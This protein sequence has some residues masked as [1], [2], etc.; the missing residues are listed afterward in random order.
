M[1][2]FGSM[3]GGRT[4]PPTHHQLNPP[5]PPPTHPPKHTN[6]D[7][8][9]GGLA[10]LAGAAVHALPARLPRPRGERRLRA[11]DGG[12]PGIKGWGVASVLCCIVLR[13]NGGAG[14]PRQSHH[15]PP[16]PTHI[17]KNEHFGVGRAQ[18]KTVVE[19]LM[20]AMVLRH[21][22]EEDSTELASG[23]SANYV[24]VRAWVLGGGR[25]WLVWECMPYMCHLCE[26]RSSIS[27]QQINPNSWA[28]RPRT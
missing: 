27:P 17:H 9:A 13:F 23:F 24:N 2:W 16:P 10:R 5:P 19:R 4:R 3:C 7:P 1:V 14:V 11:A 26:P 18:S 12:R 20:Q 8:Q 21:Y 25:L 22:L 28:P 15:I 6:N